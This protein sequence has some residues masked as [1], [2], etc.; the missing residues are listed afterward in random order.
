MSAPF[1]RNGDRA[2]SHDRSRPDAGGRPDDT[3]HRSAGHPER[4]GP[5]ARRAPPVAPQSWVLFG[6]HSVT[7]RLR[8]APASIEV[9]EVDVERTDPRAQQLQQQA[10]AAGIRVDA[11]SSRR[12]DQS[13]R[14]GRH[15]GVVARVVPQLPS[16]DFDDL[17]ARARERID[18]GDA[19][20]LL[21][22]DGVTDPRNLGACLRVADGAG[23]WA[24]IAPRDHS[25]SLT[26]VVIHTSSGGAESVPYLQV[27][28]LV[29]SMDALQD[30]GFRVFGTAD[31]AE[32]ELH[33]ADLSGPVAW[34]LGA[35][36]KGMR[37]LVRERCDHTVSIPMV[38]Q[39]ESLN[40]SVAAGIVL[41]ETLRQHRAAETQAGGAP[42]P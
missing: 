8:R 14:G 31:E 36:D 19:P 18:Q 28:N 16:L 33:G 3:S 25:C 20:V 21:L 7:A 1:S 4:S 13:A 6:F 9:I 29:R 15:Q 37:R 23:V 10:L 32:A 30:A 26:E 41:Y 5:R 34:V 27:T 24:V 35:E 38:G 12:L 22:L 40:V 17:L 11:V 39:C 42:S 2:R